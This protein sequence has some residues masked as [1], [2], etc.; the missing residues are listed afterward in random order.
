MNKCKL[1]D[2]EVLKL[3]NDDVDMRIIS[4]LSGISR[5]AIWNKI[6]KYQDS[7]RRLIL[8]LICPNCKREFKRKQCYA[9]KDKKHNYCSVKCSNSMRTIYKGEDK[10]D[11]TVNRRNYGRIARKVY[12]AN[13][14]KLNKGE[15]IHHIDGNITNND[16]D[17]LMV[18]PS[19]AEHIKYHHSLVEKG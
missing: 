5:Q 1:T 12:E 15:V 18:F 8:T 10:D 9:T 11:N 13:V 14:R 19:N 6:K 16:L 7:N 17:N 2:D 4:E 3:Y